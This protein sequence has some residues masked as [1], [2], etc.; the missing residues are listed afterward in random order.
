[1]SDCRSRGHKFFPDWSHTFTESD[2]EIISTSIHLSPTDTRM[3]IVIFHMFRTA[4]LYF[5]IDYVLTCTKVLF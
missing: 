2:Y 5:D 1:M 3:V 4:S